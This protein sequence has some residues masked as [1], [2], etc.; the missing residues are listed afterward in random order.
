[1]FVFFHVKAFQGFVDVSL[2]LCVNAWSHTDKETITDSFWLTSVL[3]NTSHWI[4]LQT[5]ISGFKNNVC[6]DA[7]VLHVQW[8]HQEHPKVQTH[9]HIAQTRT[10]HQATHT[11]HINKHHAGLRSLTRP[12]LSLPGNNKSMSSE[13][14]TNVNMSSCDTTPASERRTQRCLHKATLHSSLCSV[15]H[16]WHDDD[17]DGSSS[18]A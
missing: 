16:V 7:V 15:L 3:Q 11:Q 13:L 2:T 5:V 12:P 9:E 14:Q 6:R 18:E 4:H 1:M 10:Q 17:T 8:S